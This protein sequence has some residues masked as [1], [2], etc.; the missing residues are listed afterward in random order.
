M[1]APCY[2]CPDRHYRCHSECGKY[3]DYRKK[4]DERIELQRQQAEINEHIDRSMLN[5]SKGRKGLPQ[6]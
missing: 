1:N 2:K 3:A 6:K 5:F 4:C